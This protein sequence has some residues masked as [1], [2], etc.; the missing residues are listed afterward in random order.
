[1]DYL[2]NELGH[3]RIWPIGP[4]L[5]PND[6]GPVDRGGSSSVSVA[7]TCTWLDTCGDR[8][9]VYVC[10]GSQAMLTNKQLE[11]LTLGLEKSG[12][13]F[14]L[15]IKDTIKGH[16]E[17][18]YGM[19]PVGFEGRVVGRGVVIKGWAPQ[20]MILRH[21]A[22]C[23]FWTHCGWNS[24]LESIVSGVPMMAWPMGADQF[25]NATLLEKE[26][27]IAV[28]VCEGDEGEID[29]DEVARVLVEA[30]S[31]KWVERRG[32]ALGLS[33]AAQDAIKGGG[34]SFNNLNNFVRRL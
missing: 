8:T 33:K 16:N 4:L 6:I 32:R 9:V 13:K 1:M 20:V 18:Y 22:V 27:G 25:V 31:E 2:V 12:V 17:D 15:V 10:F 21:R 3:D 7:E 29:S 23:A 11:D 14:I 26:V 30:T 34:T 19:I 24:T 28:G 5:P